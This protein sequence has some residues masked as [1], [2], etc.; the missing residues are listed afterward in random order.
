MKT[1]LEIRAYL[2]RGMSHIASK[3]ETRG[4][5][6]GLC[7]AVDSPE[8]I[9]IIATDGR[10]LGVFLCQPNQVQY[11]TDQTLPFRLAIPIPDFRR[12][13][14][15]GDQIITVDVDDVTTTFTVND[16]SQIIRSYRANYPQTNQVIPIRAE[17]IAVIDLNMSILGN[18][19]SA[20]KIIGVTE[21]EV[22]HLRAGPPINNDVN[23]PPVHIFHNSRRFYGVIMPVRTFTMF[24][25]PSWAK[26]AEPKQEAPQ[27][28]EAIPTAPPLP[29][30]AAEPAPTQETTK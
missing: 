26:T 16:F 3:D 17:P 14:A 24:E 7:L 12:L 21:P 6:S 19:V 29:E 15:M 13:G 28:P 11:V 8:E 5:I 18:V 1:K 10:L 27:T 25:V 9:K 23:F 20:L 2:L 22:L 4:T 30:Q